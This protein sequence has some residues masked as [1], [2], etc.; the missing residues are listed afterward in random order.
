MVLRKRQ[1]KQVDHL[2]ELR[3]GHAVGSVGLEQAGPEI[4]GDDNNGQREGGGSRHSLPDAPGCG[5]A[6]APGEC[7]RHCVGPSQ[8]LPHMHGWG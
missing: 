7:E 8:F 5:A 4:Y 3:T 2:R 1:G 6:E